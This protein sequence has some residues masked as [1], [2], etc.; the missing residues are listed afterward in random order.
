MGHD[1]SGYYK[2][3]EE[4]ADTDYKAPYEAINMH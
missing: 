1:K 4:I 3:R 2:S